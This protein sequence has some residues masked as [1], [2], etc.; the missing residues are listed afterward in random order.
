MKSSAMKFVAALGVA[1]ALALTATTASF[2]QSA[3]QRQHPS[4]AQGGAAS[5]DVMAGN[6]RIGR[7]PDPWIRNELLRHY[8]SG[9]PD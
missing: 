3:P 8:H 2:A 4:Q 9:W 5:D 1:G 6:K 7:D